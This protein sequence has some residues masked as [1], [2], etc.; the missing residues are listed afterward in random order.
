MIHCAITSRGQRLNTRAHCDIGNLLRGR[1]GRAAPRRRRHSAAVLRPIETFA[2]R[3]KVLSLEVRRRRATGGMQRVD[4]PRAMPCKCTVARLPAGHTSDADSSDRFEYG[5]SRRSIFVTIYRIR[6][7]IK[8]TGCEPCVGDVG[9]VLQ[10]TDDYPDNALRNHVVV[11]SAVSSISPRTAGID[12]DTRR[13]E[14]ESRGAG[15]GW[16]KRE[17]TIARPTLTV[18]CDALAPRRCIGRY[19]APIRGTL[20]PV[21]PVREKPRFDISRKERGQTGTS[22]REG[23]LNEPG[24][25]EINNRD[26]ED[27]ISVD[28][29][30]K[31]IDVANRQTMPL[32][33]TAIILADLEAAPSVGIPLAISNAYARAIIPLISSIFSILD[34]YHAP[35]VPQFSKTVSLSRDGSHQVA[36]TRASG[37]ERIG[38]TRYLKRESVAISARHAFSNVPRVGNR[39]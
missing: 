26:S 13:K 29:P 19:T 36:R 7:V 15:G 25:K 22:A 30:R 10:R 16:K 17:G 37:V 28:G 20:S 8:L 6:R 32:P 23:Y 33:L 3:A 1:G 18:T 35:I 2:A 34:V 12:C 39:Y 4:A 21:V 5:K 27:V 38:L 24:E 14:E 31:A 9:N 11:T